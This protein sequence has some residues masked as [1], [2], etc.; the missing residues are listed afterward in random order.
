PAS[1]REERPRGARE[2][3]PP[4]EAMSLYV[5]RIERQPLAV[6]ERILRWSDEGT[7][8]G[9]RPIPIRLL[10]QSDEGFRLGDLLPALRHRLSALTIPLPSLS[11]RQGEIP[12]I[13]L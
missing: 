6:Q 2:W 12:A 1:A 10:A 5:E 3:E 13:A 7:R 11:T 4:I 8:L 9:S